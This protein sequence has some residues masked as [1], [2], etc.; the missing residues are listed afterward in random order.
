M[1]NISQTESLCLILVSDHI[2]VAARSFQAYHTI[3]LKAA[4]VLA[5]GV[6]TGRSSMFVCDKK[7]ARE[8]TAE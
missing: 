5:R 4:L 8:V 7:G 2:G 6:L 3:M 1:Q